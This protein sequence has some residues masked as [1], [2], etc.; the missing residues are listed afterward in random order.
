[1]KYEPIQSD[2]YYHI[3]NQG[4]NKENI[5]KEKRNYSYFLGLINKY[6][7]PICEVFA[8]CLLPNHFHLVLKT[9]EGVPDKVLSQKFSNLFNTYS[10]AINKAHNRTGSLFRDRFRRKVIEN[11]DYLRNLIV[12]VH[13]NPE[14][15]ELYPD[16]KKYKYSSYQSYLSKKASKLNREFV[17]GLFEDIPN[18]QY[19]HLNK[20]ITLNERLTFE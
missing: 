19:A 18:F 17:L 5:F 7:H 3:F 1:M 15:H 10:K 8:Y 20:K 14:Y 16:F 6:L 11:E 2:R 9:N 4:N 12:Y 13:L